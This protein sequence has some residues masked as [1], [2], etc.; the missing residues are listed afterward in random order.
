MLLIAFVLMEKVLKA[1]S[2]IANRIPVIRYELAFSRRAQREIDRKLLQF[3]RWRAF[4]SQPFDLLRFLV[5]ALDAS[6]KLEAMSS[7]HE[8]LSHRQNALWC[9][10]NCSERREL[11]TDWFFFMFSV[12]SE[13][14]WTQAKNCLHWVNHKWHLVRAAMQC[15][16]VSHFL[17]SFV[18]RCEKDFYAKYRKVF[19]KPATCKR[20]MSMMGE[21]ESPRRL[22]A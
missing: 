11:E 15:N 10:Q 5:S 21:R 2:W 6:S 3:F 22:I 17:A 19:I 13:A 20:L 7:A 16:N 1:R 12:E 18:R 8:I 9:M 4:I 14:Q